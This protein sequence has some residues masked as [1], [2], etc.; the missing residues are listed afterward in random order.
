LLQ[1]DIEVI[2]DRARDMTLEKDRE[3]C[4]GDGQRDEDR[5][6]ST[7]DKPEP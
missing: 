5:H 1:M 4:A 3:A 6:D 7:C 2:G